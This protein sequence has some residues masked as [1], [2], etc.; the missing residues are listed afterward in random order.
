MHSRLFHEWV[1]LILMEMLWNICYKKGV[2][3]QHQILGK[4]CNNRNSH[5]LLVGLQTGTL[6]ATWKTVCQFIIKLN[7]L[8]QYDPA[9]THPGIYQND[10]KSYIHIKNPHTNVYGSFVN[11]CQ[12]MET[13]KISFNRW[14]KKKKTNNASYVMKY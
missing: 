11:N 13:T 2:T 14:K 10:L 1:F 8:L 5:S 4:K 9:I 7:L 6:K 3:K 12:K